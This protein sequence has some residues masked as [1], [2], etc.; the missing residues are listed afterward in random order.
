MKSTTTAPKS[1][2]KPNQFLPVMGLLIA[3]CVGVIAY[4]AAPLA[5]DGVKEVMGAQEY[6]NRIATAENEK[7]LTYAF[8]VMIWLVVFSIL[9]LLVSAAIGEDPDKE[10]RLLKPPPGSSPKVLKE[11][12]KKLEQLEKKRIKQA[13]ALKRRQGKD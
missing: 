8:G 7:Y 2:K 9:M 4:F 13:E 10:E 3:I 5:I 1:K 11:Y 12:Y 6:R